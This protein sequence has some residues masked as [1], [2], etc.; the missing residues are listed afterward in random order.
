M[1]A[2]RPTSAE[3]LTLAVRRRITDICTRFDQVWSGGQQPRI[4]AFLA[5]DDS[6]AV[7]R[8]LLKALLEVEFHYRQQAGQTPHLDKYLRRFPDQPDTVRSAFPGEATDISAATPPLAQTI[9]PLI[10]PAELP[11]SLG[12]YPIEA[13]LGSGTFGVV[14][15]GRDDILHRAVAIK[16]PRPK[17]VEALG[18]ID[19]YLQE[20]RVLAGLD[21]PHIVPVHDVGHTDD[22]RCYVVYGFIEGSDL[23]TCLAQRR[24]PATE[25]ARLVASLAEALSTRTS[26]TSSTA[27]SSRPTS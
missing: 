12:R 1:N 22:G 26:A 4:E 8:E 21:H 17:I 6:A 19:S 7:R 2:P 9:V 10:R 20:A 24:Y 3:P 14:Y 11:A 16:V 25:T 5:A 18:G 27:T 23:K 13:V 15:R